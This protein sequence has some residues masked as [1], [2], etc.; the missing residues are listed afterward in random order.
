MD[1]TLKTIKALS[2]ATRLKI[3]KYLL[4]G[5]K[6]VCEIFPYIKKTQSTT[7][8]QLKK[9]VEANLLKQERRG[10]KIIYSIKDNRIKKILKILEK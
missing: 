6:C 7:S 5:E 10:K 9:L 3:I 1:N 2:D 4:N 8:L